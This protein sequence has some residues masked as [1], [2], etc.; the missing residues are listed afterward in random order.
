[1]YFVEYCS[2]SENQDGCV[3]TERLYLYH[4]F[5]LIL[6][7]S[8]GCGSLLPPSITRVYCATYH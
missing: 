3:G 1:M 5:T 7:L 8:R 4:L 6:W 2:E